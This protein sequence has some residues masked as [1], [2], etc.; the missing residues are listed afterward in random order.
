MFRLENFCCGTRAHQYSVFANNH[1]SDLLD[2]LLYTTKTNFSILPEA[3]QATI[4]PHYFDF[5]LE[6]KPE[7]VYVYWYIYL[8]Y[9]FLANRFIKTKSVNL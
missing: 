3:K 2:Q 4:E 7:C 1:V 6:S 8:S 9:K 5:H